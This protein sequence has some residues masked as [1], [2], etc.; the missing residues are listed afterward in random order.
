M[1]EAVPTLVIP[2]IKDPVRLI[3]PKLLVSI[4]DLPSAR[5]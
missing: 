3:D 1:L 4:S 2:A 5:L